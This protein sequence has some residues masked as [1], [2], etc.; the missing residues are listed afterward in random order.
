MIIRTKTDIQ[1][2]LDWLDKYD[3]SS[4][5]VE[6]TGL[7]NIKDQLIGFG[8]ATPTD[9]TGFYI[10]MREWVDGKLVTLLDENDVKPV[11][12]KLATKKLLGWNFAFDAGFA[13]RKIGVDLMP[14]LHCE[15]MLA[16]HTCDENKF[17]YGLKQ[18][19]V[20]LFGA[21]VV[22]EQVDMKESIKANGGTSTEF[23]KANSD[24]MA[25]YG[26]QDNVLTCRNYLHW[27]AELERQG[28]TKFYNEE[29]LDLQKEVTFYMQYKG[30]PVDVPAL[31]KARADIQLEMEKLEDQI[32]AQIKPL[33]GN[34][35]DWYISR[36]FPFKLTPAFKNKLGGVLNVHDWPR[37]KTG[38]LSFSKAD[39]DR[40][41]KKGTI[42]T[43]STF[44]KIVMQIEK[45]SAELI[46]N[47]Q[48]ELLKETGIKYAFNLL[49]T[50]HLK[51]LFFK[52]NGGS[53][54]EQALSFTD[55]GSPQI[56]D[57][58]LDTM[59]SKYEWAQTLRVYRSLS[60]L[61]GTYIDG[62][63]ERSEDG[64]FYPQ[65]FQH[66]T[67]SGRYGSNIQQLPR[68]IE[69]GSDHE[70][71]V[72][73]TNL[74]RTFF[75]AGPG[76]M[77][78]DDDYESL[79]P[80][81]FAHVSGDEGLR[82]IFRKGHDFYSTIAIATEGLAQYSADKKAEN[83]LGK[84]NKA[85]RQKAKAYSLGI[86][87][88]MSGYKLA[89]ELGIPQADAERLVNQYL[90]AYPALKAWMKRSK[91]QACLNGEIRTLSGR[92][93]RFPEL[94]PLYRKYGDLL[95]DS[96]EL[97]KE[98]H[99]SPRDYEFAKRAART[100]KNAVNNASNVQ[101]Q[102]FAASI[103]NKASIQITREFKRLNL[104]AYICASIHDEIIV[105]CAEKE[106]DTVRKVVQDRMENCVQLS[107]KLKAPASVGYT[108]MEAKG[109]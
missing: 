18:V 108:F 53:L 109:A 81:I 59:A 93:R 46:R 25:K 27:S 29:V 4:F 20:D 13:L 37:T 11:V 57:E 105:R 28:L 88:G 36:H 64:V 78:V 14:A 87:Y 68:P 35:H 99:D 39:I 83:Y 43:Q 95:F 40:A 85:A 54:D 26:L 23:Y 48:L 58:F 104:S 69:A 97:W 34:F 103:V 101:I 52:A 12:E 10:I 56:N 76:H 49:S 102:G 61:R 42:D 73:F 94:P 21:A 91:E 50:D 70:L 65:F 6:T 72:H 44:Y 30:I 41:I 84:Q 7:S 82:E 92:V 15:V 106:V 32:Q 79:E 24:L 47:V 2:A 62:I 63:L 55:K 16:C 74:I 5:D 96:L 77:F 71:V 22:T 51:R 80:H 100:A 90:S 60:K 67:V 66:R 107:I 19:S 3:V 86:P 38:S 75:I 9:L 17:T 98:Y 33:L 45:P 8:C 1:K 89:F 31:E